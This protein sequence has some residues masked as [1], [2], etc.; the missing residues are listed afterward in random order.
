MY[1]VIQQVGESR[2]KT[3]YLCKS[4]YILISSL[5]VAEEV[6]TEGVLIK[7]FPREAFT[8]K[9]LEDSMHFL[10]NEDGQRMFEAVIRQWMK[11]IQVTVTV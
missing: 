10:E 1:E 6:W 11:K 3:K 2:L 9:C 4:L 5:R 7:D 8:I